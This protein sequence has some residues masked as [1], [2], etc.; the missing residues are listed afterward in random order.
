VTLQDAAPLAVSVDMKSLAPATTAALTPAPAAPTPPAPTAPTPALKQETAKKEAKKSEPKQE[1][2]KEP[3]KEPKQEPKR[4]PPAPAPTPAPQYG[5]DVAA[6]SIKIGSS[7]SGADVFVNAEHRGVTP[8]TVTGIRPGAVSILVN[9]EGKSRFSQKVNLKPGET[10]DLGTVKLGELFGEVSIDSSPSHAKIFFDGGDIGAKTPVTVRKVRRD[11]TH[12][13]KLVLEG[14]KT[15]ERS[16]DM[17]DTESKK[18]DV[19]LEREE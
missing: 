8:I 1:P 2:K 5:P 18:F 10:L 17:G 6:G 9:K 12:S 14:Y 11:K 16:F 3:V 4:E 15:W 13:L 19:Q 7:P